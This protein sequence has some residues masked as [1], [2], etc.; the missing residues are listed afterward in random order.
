[1]SKQ[2]QSFRT[3][4]EVDDWLFSNPLRCPGALHMLQKGPTVLSYGLQV[5]STNTAKRGPF[6]HPIS[7]F[8]IPLQIATERE[9]A[10]SLLAGI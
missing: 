2:V 9:L 3:P 1:M 4:G 6:E 7:K 10:R 8:Q 5:N